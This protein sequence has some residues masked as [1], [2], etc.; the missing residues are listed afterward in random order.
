MVATPE[1]TPEIQARV[2]PALCALHNFIR[3]HDPDD[4][5]DR[6]TQEIE[7]RPLVPSAAELRNR[8]SQAEKNR[9]IAR[10]E[11]IV[12]DMWADYIS[13]SDVPQ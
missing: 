10:Q 7:Q 5:D 4:L 12:S 3:V 8:V 13:K 9:A 6:D 1:Y 2:V 11:Q